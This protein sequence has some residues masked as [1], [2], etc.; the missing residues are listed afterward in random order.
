MEKCINT[1]SRSWVSP[2]RENALKKYLRKNN[3]EEKCLSSFHLLYL[4]VNLEKCKGIIIQKYPTVISPYFLK[5]SLDGTQYKQLKFK[6]YKMRAGQMAQ[7]VQACHVSLRMWI[8]ISWEKWDLVAC[9]Y[10]LRIS[11]GQWELPR[12]SQAN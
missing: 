3:K 7:Q 1:L 6:F 5:Y 4:T 12:S 8:H 2:T 11:W 9:T 10:N